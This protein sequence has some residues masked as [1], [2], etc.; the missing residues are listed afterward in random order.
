MGCLES[1]TAVQWCLLL[2]WRSPAPWRKC[3]ESAT[4]VQLCLLT[5]ELLLLG[6]AVEADGGHTV[7]PA[8]GRRLTLRVNNFECAAFN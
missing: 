4:I 7:A 1:A 5:G 2:Y 8:V 6:G 3:L